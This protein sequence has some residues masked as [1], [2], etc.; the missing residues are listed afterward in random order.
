MT[1]AAMEKRA[2]KVRKERKAKRE[3]KKGKKAK[4]PGR[5]Y[6]GTLPAIPIVIS[7]E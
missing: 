2:K 3:R 5:W 6:V 7:G 4:K 1:A